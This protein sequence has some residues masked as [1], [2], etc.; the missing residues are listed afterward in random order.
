MKR[1]LASGAQAIYQI[2]PAFRIGESGGLHNPEFT[3]LEWYRCGDSMLEGIALLSELVAELLMLST[4]KVITVR[5]AF[6]SL[7]GFDPL[8]LSSIELRTKCQSAS[9]AIPESVDD[10][11]WDTWF[12]LLFTEL[13]QPKLGQDTPVIIHDYPASQAAL[14]R[15][16]RGE[17]D[18]AER[19]EWPVPGTQNGSP[20]AAVVEQGVYRLL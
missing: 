4:A 12:E 19:F 11:D 10:E 3:M 9:I 1:L 20:M 7:A 5:D 17:P 16:R 2:A 15:I 18:V 6:E 8:L 13:V 14:A